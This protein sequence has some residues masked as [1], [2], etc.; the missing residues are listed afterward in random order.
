MWVIRWGGISPIRAG[1][2]AER[3]G[4][5]VVNVAEPECP[6]TDVPLR[7]RMD[8]SSVPLVFAA[9]CNDVVNAYREI[10]GVVRPDVVIMV[11]GASLFDENEIA[12]GEW[13]APCTTMFDAWFEGV[14]RRSVDA[15]SS[16]GATV[17]WATQAY[18]R[19]VDDGRTSLLDDQT[20]CLNARAVDVAVA[21][22]GGLGLLGLG[23][24]TCPGR[25]CLVERDGFE[26]RRDGTHYRDG[27]ASLAN[28]WMLG[29]V[30]ETP[31][32][33]RTTP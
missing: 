21:S 32:W 18:Y 4:I 19:V 17:Y 23:E 31:P 11:F 3:L 7:R 24:W 25:E 9:R 2:E 12:P 13:H 22:D 28:V 10:V 27:G 6:L 33:E 30:F 5:E 8:A 20:D 16:S 29:Q 26:L 15:L 1:E 14:I